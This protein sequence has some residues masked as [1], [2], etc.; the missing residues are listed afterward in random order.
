MTN[1]FSGE[2]PVLTTS[3]ALYDAPPILPNNE[4]VFNDKDET[5][6]VIGTALYQWKARNDLEISFSRNDVIEVLEQAEM[7]WRGRLQKKPY[8]KGWF[9]KSYI[10]L[11]G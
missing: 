7:R 3:S 9:P 11:Y 2:K 10:K 5:V 1:G 4:T 8:V 6:I